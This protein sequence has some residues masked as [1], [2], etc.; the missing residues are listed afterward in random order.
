MRSVHQQ[1]YVSLQIHVVKIIFLIA[2]PLQITANCQRQVWN[3]ARPFN[4][5]YTVYFMYLFNIHD[6][7]VYIQYCIQSPYV[8]VISTLKQRNICITILRFSSWLS[9]SGQ[10]TWVKEPLRYPRIL[11]LC[12]KSWIP[13]YDPTEERFCHFWTC[14]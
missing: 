7:T 4:L 2:D 3:K 10:L 5:V 14:L 6:Y 1:N 8:W 12:K 9:V 11:Y 13:F